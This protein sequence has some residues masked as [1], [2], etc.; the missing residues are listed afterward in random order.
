MM[1][2]VNSAIFDGSMRNN[3]FPTSRRSC[4]QNPPFSPI[5]T[6]ECSKMAFSKISTLESV[7][8]KMRF[9]WPFFTVWTVLQTGEKISLFSNKNGYVWTRPLSQV[10]YTVL[11]IHPQPC[12]PNFSY[13]GRCN[14]CDKVIISIGRRTVFEMQ[15][16]LR[17]SCV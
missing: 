7:F 11:Q 5:H 6:R 13:V 17:R 2:V 8:Q 16:F 15:Q 3:W 14:Q 1:N 9:R 10:L 4:F 12:S